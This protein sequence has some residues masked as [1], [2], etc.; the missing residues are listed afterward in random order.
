[1]PGNDNAAPSHGDPKLRM[2]LSF[3]LVITPF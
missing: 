3:G 1:V 2:R